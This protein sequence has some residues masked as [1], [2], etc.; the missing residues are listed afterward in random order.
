MNEAMTLE[1]DPTKVL[2][3]EDD[4]DDFLIFS[5]AIEDIS[6]KIVLSRATDGGMLMDMLHREL[7]DML[8][9]DL[10]MPGLDGRQCLQMVR[11][12]RK[13]DKLPVIVYTCLD[14]LKNIQYCY[15]E[16]SNMYLIKPNSISELKTILERIFTIDW[17][18]ALYYPPF[19]HF[20]LKGIA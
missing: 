19:D 10:R 20:V 11:S 13:F 14:D 2:I 7:P 4:D 17:K 16:G 1:G 9:L 3:G 15:Q 18:K 5:L 12:D 8:F 6:Y